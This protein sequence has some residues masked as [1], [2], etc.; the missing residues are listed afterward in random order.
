[1][2]RGQIISK[3]KETPQLL[4]L[5]K[6]NILDKKSYYT[7]RFG[8]SSEQMTKMF[9]A[10]TSVMVYSPEQI[11]A[12]INFL[13]AN[14]VDE[15]KLLKGVKSMPRVIG[16]STNRIKSQ[17]EFY[18]DEFS[19]TRPQV[20]EMIN[21]YIGVLGC[22]QQTVKEKSQ[23]WKNEFGLD[24]NQFG[25]I[26][27]ILPRLVGLS[28]ESVQ[29]KHGKLLKLGVTDA[30]IAKMPLILTVPAEDIEI[31]YLIWRQ[32]V[33]REQLLQRPNLLLANQNKLFAR[34]R[35]FQDRGENLYTNSLAMSEETFVARYKL[36]TQDL[37]ETYPL[38]D[39]EIS[40]MQAAIKQSTP[41]KTFA[42]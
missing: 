28:T 37:M 14:G 26:L 41:S 13:V 2:S 16:L 7:T 5:S 19:L 3:L 23:F 33:S 39:A 8:A 34:L 15:G 27:C 29:Q 25:T 42:L 24:D 6:D 20:A 21:K 32:V 38:T 10:C 1:M 22:S 18:M 9:K 36:S 11:E 40:K 12:K 17:I 31:R 4:S 35:F 30:E